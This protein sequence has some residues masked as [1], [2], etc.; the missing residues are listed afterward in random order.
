MDGTDKVVDI[1]SVY[2]PGNTMFHLLGC[3]VGEGKAENIAWGNAEFI[4]EKSETM[5]EHASFSGAGSS[6]YTY[7]T[8]SG[9][10][11]LGLLFVEL[12]LSCRVVRLSGFQVVDCQNSLNYLKSSK[13]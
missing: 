1:P 9:L 3:L 13:F 4:Y 2:H 8:F 12:H 10:H 5:G 7:P 6:Y 11:G